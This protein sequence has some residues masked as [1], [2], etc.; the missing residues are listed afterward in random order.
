M[1]NN[2]AVLDWD[3]TFFGFTVARVLPQNLDFK[4]LDETLLTM[5]QE[6][7]TLAYWAASPTDEESVAAAR[8]CNGFLADKKVTFV[9]DADEMLQ[10]DSSTISEAIVEEYA[11][12]YPTPELEALALQAGVYSRFRVDPR[13]PEGRF[14]DL[15]KLWINN[16]VNKKIADAVLIVRKEG[17][18]VGMVTVGR[19]GDRADIGLIAVDD[20]MRGKGLGL[21]LVRAAQEWALNKGFTSA[22][23]VTQG[24]NISAC[25][26]YE[27]CGYRVDKVE[28]IYH[29]WIQP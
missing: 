17:K 24:E 13:I 28:N 5:R 15:Y 12:L 29:F 23:V 20:S 10:R 27:K 3:S 2:Y 14:V 11:D 21:T 22:Q 16:S 9:I 26:F 25:R 19:K 1:K 8:R 7:V 6:N 4:Q 18:A